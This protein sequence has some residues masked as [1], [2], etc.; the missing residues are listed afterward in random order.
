MSLGNQTTGKENYI[1]GVI[2]WLERQKGLMEG[3]NSTLVS[4]KDEGFI[5]SCNMGNYTYILQLKIWNV[6]S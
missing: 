2:V 5:K 6:F 1:K 3:M 4:W